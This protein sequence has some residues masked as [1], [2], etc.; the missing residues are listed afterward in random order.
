[1]SLPNQP[2][3]PSDSQAEPV[4]APSPRRSLSLAVIVPLAAAAAE[5]AP[6]ATPPRYW[7]S[8]EERAGDP[9]LQKQ[10]AQEFPPG[11]SELEGVS[12]R[13]FVQLLGA[14]LA[15]TGAACY[16]PQQ[17][18][19][20]YVRRPPEVTP[21][22]P[23]DFASSHALEGYA[24]G[25]L[26]ESQAG[27]PTKVEGNGLHPDSQGA[28]TALEQALT[29]GLYDDDRAKAIRH[30]GGGLAWRSLL[31]VIHDHGVRLATDGGAKLRFLME[32]TASPLLADLRARI[33]QKFPKAK[34][35]S[36]SSVASEGASE[37]LA[38]AFGKP[39]EARHDL[40]MARVIVSLD[41]DFLGDGP[42]QVR[43]A[44]Q[45][46]A[47]RTPGPNMSRLYVAEPC[48]TVT[49]TMADHRLRIRGGDVLALA[50]ALTAELAKDPLGAAL[51][52]L[53]QAPRAPGQVDSRW[54][55]A[56][57]RD[58]ARNHGKCVVIAGRRQPAAVH[59]LA[60]AINGALNNSGTTVTYWAPGVADPAAGF[61][62]LRGLVQ[63]IASDNVDT[64]VI[65]AENPVY[66]APVDFKLGKLLERVPN[67]IYL[68]SYADGTSDVVT[69]FIPK[70]HMLESWGDGRGL[71]GTVSLVQPLIAPLW[72]SH[73][74]SD[75]LA[76]FLDEGDKGSHALLQEYW[77]K[78]AIAEG[79]ATSAADFEGKWEGWLGR[80]IIEK[81]GA[82]PE[83]GA[84]VAT[85]ALA[86]K[87]GAL[88]QAAA[89]A[90]SGADL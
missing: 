14:S 57:A 81:S 41:A 61:E 79:R 35:V 23:L 15:V 43:L 20:P 65:T 84:T 73:E 55:T 34:F 70:A 58:L 8:L 67:T 30:K 85:G 88:V 33:L 19:V 40:T 11:A 86:G 28:T 89:A 36:F 82:Q 62:S 22:N 31:G 45:F 54:V 75:L 53:G 6:R 68:G 64:L 49:G 27:R 29:L 44:R 52:P 76:A 10:A 71:D 90:T 21:G 32:P 1:M 4:D 37:G 74:P 39:V 56:V 12:R 60:A 59:A 3:Q 16:R 78:R 48:P 83:A 66:G 87:L 69:T 13:S 72:T 42:E 77:Q 2:D 5:P 80:G 63:D 18:I 7:R 51:A 46:S 9:A 26:V 24:L 25:L 17:K 47:G 50:Q 38:A